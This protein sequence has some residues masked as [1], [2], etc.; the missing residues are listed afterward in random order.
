MFHW[1]K[2]MNNEQ[3]LLATN[4]WTGQKENNTVKMVN[5]CFS[6]KQKKHQNTVKSNFCPA[7]AWFGA[8]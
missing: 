8:Q 1:S 6:F 7:L 5:H 4:F 2:E 3:H